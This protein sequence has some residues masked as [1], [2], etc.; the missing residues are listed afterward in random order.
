MNREVEWTR[1]SRWRA[2]CLG[3]SM[4][5]ALSL[6]WLLAAAAPGCSA[7][8]RDDKNGG[9]Y[10]WIQHIPRQA[11][12]IAS[13][14]PDGSHPPLPVPAFDEPRTDEELAEG[15][16]P[17]LIKGH[18]VYRGRP[19]DV[20]LIRRFS[21]SL[22]NSPS[23]DPRRPL[24][25][26]Q[27]EG[28]LQQPIFGA[29]NRFVVRDHTSWP[30]STQVFVSTTSLGCSATMIGVNT[31][32]S[33]A[34]C[35]YDG[36]YHNVVFA[37]PGYDAVDPNHAPF[38]IYNDSCVFGIVPDGWIHNTN[39]FFYDFAILDFSACDELQLGY[40]TGWLGWWSDAPVANYAA[41]IFGYPGTC[42]GLTAY[43]QL[44]GMTAPVGAVLPGPSAGLLNDRAL[45][46]SEGQS[47]AGVFIS[48]ADTWVVGNAAGARDYGNGNVIN[49]HRRLD[50]TVFAF[51]Q[52]ASIDF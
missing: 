2:R 32:I 39:N 34:H 45:D 43:P 47:G 35:F 30:W 15:L 4:R 18:D 23:Y 26:D 44:C 5:P 1:P 48:G 8:D 7:S 27:G 11:G 16:R 31:A 28:E 20:N 46:V 17:V 24:P 42:Q 52:Q 36:T 38:G 51:L 40:S 49:I 10:E 50:G 6:G 37:A 22:P 14:V 19:L 33:A 13:A 3:R 41:S 25:K 9:P 12:S 29:D 21:A